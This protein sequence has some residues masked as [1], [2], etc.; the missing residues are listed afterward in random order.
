MACTIH[1]LARAH[2]HKSRIDAPALPEIVHGAREAGAALCAGVETRTWTWALAARRRRECFRPD[3]VHAHLATPGLAS[4]AWWIAGGTPLSLSFHLLPAERWPNDYVL[5]VSS[6]LVLQALHASSSRCVFVAV[7][8]ADREALQRRFPR[9]R[10][11]LAPNCPS[12]PPSA[13]ARPALLPYPPNCVRLLSVGRL[14]AQKG[15]DRMLAALATPEL[16]AL[17]WH[18]LIAG[19]GAQRGELERAIARAALG[20]SVQ[21]LGSLP[22]HGLYPQAELVLCPSRFEG[23]PLVPMEALR[24]GVPVVLS[25]LPS[26]RELSP[27]TLLPEREADWPRTLRELLGSAHARAALLAQQSPHLAADG[28]GALWDACSAIYAQLVTTRPHA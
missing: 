16:R 7:S 1:E 12:P 15:F 6:R 19:E 20:Q 14:V 11:A 5:R 13:A 8:G 24:A 25:N 21:L 18:W 23:A 10:L 9:A 27:A 2:G 22:S 17:P 26:H 4:A 28:G 3:V